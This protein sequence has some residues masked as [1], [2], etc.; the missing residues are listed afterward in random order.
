MGQVY[1]GHDL[2]S[3][4][5]IVIKVMHDHLS[6]G[7]ACSPPAF[8]ANLR[9]RGQPRQAVPH[10]GVHRRHRLRLCRDREI[11][12]PA[13]PR[14]IR[15]LGQVLYAAHR[16]DIMKKRGRRLGN[17]FAIED[18]NEDD[19]GRPNC[20]SLTVDRLLHP[21]EKLTGA[22]MRPAAARRLR[23][24]GT[25]ARANKS[26]V[27]ADLYLGVILYRLLAG[28]A[29]IPGPRT[30]DDPQ[31]R[32]VSRRANVLRRSAASPT[33]LA[34]SRCW[35]TAAAEQEPGPSGPP[36]PSNSRNG[37]CRR[38]TPRRC[39]PMRSTSSQIAGDHRGQATTRRTAST[40]WRRGC[41]SRSPIMRLAGVQRKRGRRF[42]RRRAG[43]DPHHA[44]PTRAPP[45]YADEVGLLAAS[46][47]PL[48]A[49]PATESN[50][51]LYMVKQDQGNPPRWSRSAPSSNGTTTDKP[52][53]RRRYQD[54]PD[55][56][57]CR[58]LRRSS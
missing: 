18:S 12:S 14:W 16:S 5:Q 17:L 36:T 3:G 41:R 47:A 40:E 58:E 44:W 48:G 45:T 24:S 52:G 39:R 21:F 54:R 10:H 19:Q 28:D 55:Q 8:R 30:A 51:D 4:E 31:R 13:Y 1:L 33:C 50:L 11:A 38:S 22:A 2:R 56:R 43:P 34:R 27:R 25:S 6:S 42:R 20:D 9:L 53:P 26:I 23:R 15:Q 29:P 32:I 37:I 46:S 35:F 7:H 57:I 49:S